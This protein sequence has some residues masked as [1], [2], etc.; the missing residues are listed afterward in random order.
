MAYKLLKSIRVHSA[1][2][3]DVTEDDVVLPSGL[4]S[5]RTVVRHPGAVVV[6]PMLTD[7]TALFLRQYRHAVQETIIELPAGALEKGE[8]PLLAAKRELAEEAGCQA[9]DWISLGSFYPAPGFCSEIQHA[10]LARGLSPKTLPPDEDEIIEPFTLDLKD[11]AKL[12][13]RG[14]I[15]DSKTI[16]VIARAQLLALI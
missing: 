4:K 7:S 5:K 11:A 16:A 14:E 8:D 2:Y 3:F 9:E 10:F 13:A 6:L 15:K 1:K 12:I